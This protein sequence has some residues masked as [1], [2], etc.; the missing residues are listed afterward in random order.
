MYAENLGVV[1]GS[2][3]REITMPTGSSLD[4]CVSCFIWYLHQEKNAPG[5]VG[6]NAYQGSNDA[7]AIENGKC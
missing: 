1:A 6:G 7:S 2:Q 3:P 4:T 5:T